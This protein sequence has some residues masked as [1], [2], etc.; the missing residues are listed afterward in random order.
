MQKA[1]LNL[2]L[3]A[4]LPFVRHPEYNDSFEERWLYEA[5][6][7]TYIPLLKVFEK[8]LSE[9]VYFRVTMSLTPPLME[10]LSDELLQ[11]RYVRHMENL[12][13][14]IELEKKRTAD[15]SEFYALACMYEKKFKECLT[16]FRDRYKC[17]IVDAF[18]EVMETG[19]LEIITCCATHGFLP[20]MSLH[21][22]AV[23]A[24]ITMGRI[25]YE[26]HLGRPPRGIWLA[27]CGYYPRHDRFLRDNGIQFFFTE[28]HALRDAT[29]GG[30]YSLY[31]PILCPQT[32]V[33]AFA[34]DP[35]S[36]SQVWSSESGYPGDPY[37]REF[38][39]DVGYD[40]DFD[41]IAP[42]IHESG[43][44][45]NTGVKYYRITGKTDQK[46][47]YSEQ[48]ALERVASHAYHFITSRCEQADRVRHETEESPLFTCPYD[49]ELYGHW[50]YEGPLFIQA[51]FETNHNM[52]YPL[53]PVTAPEYLS[54]FH[55]HPVAT[56]APSSWGHKGYSEFWLNETN[57]WI[58][59]HLHKA[60][61]RMLELVDNFA[62]NSDPVLER[63][64]NQAGRE[65]MLAQSSDWAFI[66]RSGTCIDYA[67]K[68]TK[69]HLIN[70]NELYKQIF[71][72]KI[73]I[74][75]LEDL[76]Y[77][78]N[79]FKEFNFRIYL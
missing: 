52:G 23:N 6:T 32:G 76:E 40:L 51:L 21:P 73:N 30:S 57:D 53:Q 48:K 65:L 31:R 58:Y 71:D 64:L 67:E 17:N 11:Q 13:S 24:Q 22:R 19:A 78:N 8:L 47:P 12:I 70:L 29:P 4:H 74:Q 49:A 26:K 72:N 28:S 43:T 66:I 25:N 5:I 27:E 60:E 37:Y 20:I 75:F 39:R 56:P 68:R 9:G 54:Y 46:E 62:E 33:A 34:R 61:E 3:H 77:R 36:S 42:Y 18:K 63:A 16:F 55:N 38:Y 1:Y 14:L 10:M 35:E 45:L 15:E 79:I 59:H 2:V 50:W 44:R 7:E 41:Y 69:E